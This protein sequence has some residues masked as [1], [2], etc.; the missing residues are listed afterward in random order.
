[1]NKTYIVYHYPCTDGL[2][3]AAAAFLKHPSATY[4]KH[5]M[6]RKDD[7]LK[8]L[9]DSQETDTIYFL[10]CAPR[11]SDIE[12]LKGEIIVLDHHKSNKEDLEKLFASGEIS[13]IF[14]MKR[15][16]AGIAWDYF[17]PNQKRPIMI[18]LVEDRDLWNFKDFRSRAFFYGLNFVNLT[19]QD[20]C[21]VLTSSSLTQTLV[22]EGKI[23]E[24][25]VDKRI[26]ENMRN[27]SI[28]KFHGVNAIFINATESVSDQGDMMLKIFPQAAIAIVYQ[29]H[30]DTDKYK[31]SLRSRKEESVDVSALA[32]IYNG[33]GHATASGCL[34]TPE[35]FKEIMNG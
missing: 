27:V 1:M 14:D 11:L 25:F 17:H 33:G 23:I 20:Y 30:A 13:G 2:T 34:I 22:S 12:I 28:K 15:S 29:H 3:A 35:Q 32:R 7:Y 18:D 24:K 5:S 21:E 4:I 9:N 10:D 8:Q 6:E 26:I 31:L 16:G 19:I